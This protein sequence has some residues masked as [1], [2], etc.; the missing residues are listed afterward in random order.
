MRRTGKPCFKSRVSAQ[1]ETGRAL[2]QR[3]V[4]AK[5][6][7]GVLL[8][9]RTVAALTEKRKSEGVAAHV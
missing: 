1:C 5:L 9:S 4:R 6:P 2:A 3:S 8:R 7:A